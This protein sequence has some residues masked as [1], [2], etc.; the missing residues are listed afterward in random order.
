M[1]EHEL[2]AIIEFAKH[3]KV[4]ELDA[5]TIEIIKALIQSDAM[6]DVALGVKIGIDGLAQEIEKQTFI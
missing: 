6:K 3:M 2:K 5:N 4:D 1:K